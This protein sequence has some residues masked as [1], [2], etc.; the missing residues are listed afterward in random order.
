MISSND[1]RNGVTIELDGVLFQVIEFQHVKPGKGSAFV[2]T[3]LKNLQTGGV[4]DR[5]FNAGERVPAA[6]VEKREMQ[7]LYSSG[8]DYTFMDTE[9]FEQLTLHSADIG[10]GVLFLKENMTCYVVLYKG[11]SIGVELPNSVDLRIVETDPGFKGDTATGGTKPA[12]LET[13]AVVKVPLFVEQGEIISV[14]T[15]TGQYLGRA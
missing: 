13:G 5:T 14:D 11:T 3:K 7:F 1:F 8:D 2:R 12:K 6:R 9:T 4:V 10:D 15:R